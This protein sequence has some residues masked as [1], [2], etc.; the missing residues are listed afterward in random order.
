M[1]HKKDKNIMNNQQNSSKFFLILKLIIKK[2]NNITLNNY[3]GFRKYVRLND[4]YTE[5]DEKIIW[6]NRDTES[7]VNHIQFLIINLKKNII[8]S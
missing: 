8:N 3:Q 6:I 4:Y 7:R 5:K 2:T 1:D